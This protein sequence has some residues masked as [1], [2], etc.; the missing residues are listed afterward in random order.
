[1]EAVLT[2]TQN[3][4][5]KLVLDDEGIVV[6]RQQFKQLGVWPDAADQLLAL[7]PHSRWQNAPVVAADY[8]WVTRVIEDSLKGVDIG[9]NYPAFFQKLLTNSELRQFFLDR[10]G[11]RLRQA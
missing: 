10:L 7:M 11:E 5:S 9:A 2:S 1:M 6:L 3:Q 4:Q 8:D